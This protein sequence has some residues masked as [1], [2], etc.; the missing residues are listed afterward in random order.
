MLLGYPGNPC[1]GSKNGNSCYE[2]F[3]SL[4]RFS[5]GC[6][7]LLDFA[8]QLRVPIGLPYIEEERNWYGNNT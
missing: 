3:V 4:E 6:L 2:S 1:R 7:E 5:L 8:L